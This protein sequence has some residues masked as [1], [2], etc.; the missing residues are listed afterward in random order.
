MA[1]ILVRTVTADRQ[2]HLI[3]KRGQQV[4]VASGVFIVVVVLKACCRHVISAFLHPVQHPPCRCL[5]KRSSPPPILDAAIGEAALRTGAI[6]PCI[7]RIA[8]IHLWGF[9]TGYQWVL[10]DS[11]ADETVA[12][13]AVEDT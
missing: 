2:V 11:T 7:E 10:N 1:S 13:P 4:H 8:R 12:L 6:T 3:G 5:K 9:Q